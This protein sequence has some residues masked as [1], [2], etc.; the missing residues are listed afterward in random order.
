MEI[1]TELG[2]LVAVLLKDKMI[3]VSVICG[4]LQ[5]NK[6]SNW[7]DSLITGLAFYLLLSFFVP[8]IKSNY[9]DISNDLSAIIKKL[10][11]RKKKIFALI[12][13]CNKEELKVIYA[14]IKNG[15]NFV[16][17]DLLI[18]NKD[19]YKSTSNGSYMESDTFFVK[20]ENNKQYIKVLNGRFKYFKKAYKKTKGN[21][22]IIDTEGNVMKEALKVKKSQQ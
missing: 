20:K 6:T 13:Q 7:V 14:L 18:Q 9:K 22:D 4:L 3:I 2:K 15:N 1:L 19:L 8:L 10:R 21:L 12:G 17:T 16:E 11:E 5:Y